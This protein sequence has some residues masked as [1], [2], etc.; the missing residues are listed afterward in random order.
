[1][2]NNQQ[3][4]AEQVLKMMAEKHGQ[5]PRPMVLMS[6]V[7]PEWVPRQ[8]AEQKFVMDLPHVPA[9]YKQLIMIAATVA[10]GHGECTKTQIMLAQK[11][12]LTKEEIGE[13]ILTARY[14]LASTVFNTSLDGLELLVGEEGAA[15]KA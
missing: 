15:A 1:M 12:G 7:I 3:P 2:E 11:A 14:A 6:R 13:A 4:T 10:V 5:A 8:A 9:K